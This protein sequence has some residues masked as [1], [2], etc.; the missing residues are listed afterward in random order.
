M[1]SQDILLLLKLVSLFQQEKDNLSQQEKGRPI[2]LRSKW[3]DWEDPEEESLKQSFV[4]DL[5]IKEVSLNLRP[6]KTVRDAL[7]EE[8]SIRNLADATGISKSEVSNAL[9]RC[10]FSGLA[11]PDRLTGIPRV[12]Q[13][14]L[15]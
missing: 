15:R 14:A 9:Q 7:A 12:N 6:T 1:K 10:Y 4:T 3:K 8:Y 13:R 2:F 11:K 5:D